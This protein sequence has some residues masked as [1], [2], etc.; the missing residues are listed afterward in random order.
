MANLVQCVAK[1]VKNRPINLTDRLGLASTAI[2]GHEVHR[3]PLIGESKPKLKLNISPFGDVAGGAGGYTVDGIN[4]K[5]LAQGTAAYLDCCD[6][7]NLIDGHL[8]KAGSVNANPIILVPGGEPMELPS[9]FTSI[10]SFFADTVGGALGSWL[11]DNVAGDLK[12]LAALANYDPDGGGILNSVK[13]NAPSSLNDMV[14]SD[15]K[16]VPCH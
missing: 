9:P 3:W 14:W 16:F 5:W 6:K 1:F 4:Y 15:L 7:I 8:E 11:F 2:K 10:F 13:A 12:L